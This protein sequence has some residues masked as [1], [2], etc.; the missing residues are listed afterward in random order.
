MVS[1]KKGLNNH[2]P[3]II[4]APALSIAEGLH[5]GLF[6]SPFFTKWQQV[7]SSGFGYQIFMLKKVYLARA[8][9]LAP[10]A[11]CLMPILNQRHTGQARLGV[12]INENVCFINFLNIIRSN[13]LRRGA[14]AEN[15][16]I[17]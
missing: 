14:H 5:L 12:W 15:S 2:Q 3:L 17:L 4:R 13:N 16:A 7:R 6:T 1:S 11:L 9:Y 10:E 8:F